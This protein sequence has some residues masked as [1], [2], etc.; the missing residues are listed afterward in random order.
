MRIRT[1]F[2]P[3]HPCVAVGAI[4]RAGASGATSAGGCRAG[5]TCRSRCR[6]RAGER[7]GVH[8]TRHGVRRGLRPGALHALSRPPR[9]RHARSVPVHEGDRHALVHGAGRSRWLSRSAIRARPQ[10]LRQCEG[11]V[12]VQPDSAVLQPGH[13][14]ALHHR[15][16]DAEHAPSRAPGCRRGQQSQTVPYASLDALAQPFDLRLMRRVA[17]FKA[18]YAATQALDLDISI[19]STTKSGNQ[20]WAGTFGFSDAVDLPVPVQTRTTDLGLAAEWAGSRGSARLGYDGSFFRNDLSTIVWD[21]PLRAT[22]SQTLG[23]SQGRMSLWPDSSLNAVSASGLLNLPARSRATA[24]VSVGSWWQNDPLI[25]FTVNSAL[26]TIVLDRPTAD[27]QARVTSM[28]YSFTSRP[29]NDVSFTARYRLYDFDN[30]TPI[31]H[32]AN[33]VAYD[34]TVEAFTDGGTSPTASSARRS[35]RM[36]VLTPA[37]NAAPACAAA[38]H[39]SRSTR[40]FGPSTRR[41]RIRCA[42]RRI[43]RVSAG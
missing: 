3:R 1:S 14:D 41:R 16:R 20:P 34:T 15:C 27:A 12:R 40:R 4:A 28:N 2:S 31:F 42:C 6:G 32:V 17:A 18:T 13:A 11:V 5:R 25:P 8:R 24:Y 23:P 9:R 21:N 22:D 43:R 26:P 30:R 37:P 35:T 10:R 33:T 38:T 19:R 29:A 36:V 7:R 39:A